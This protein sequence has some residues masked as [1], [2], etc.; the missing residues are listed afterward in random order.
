M[1][2]P[3]VLRLSSLVV[4]V[5]GLNPGAGKLSGTNTYLVGAGRRR[6]LV[7][8]GEGRAGYMPALLVAM[9]DHG[10]DDL[11]DV[12]LTHYHHDHIGGLADLRK[13]FAGL[14]AWKFMPRM[15]KGPGDAE[16]AGFLSVAADPRAALLRLLGLGAGAD[17]GE[18]HELFDG[19]TLSTDDGS[20]TLRVLATPGHTADHVCLRLVEEPSVFSGDCV[21]G[22]STAV[23]ADLST[24]LTSLHRLRAE[25][26]EGTM[27]IYPGHGPVVADAKAAVDYYIQHRQSRET[28][29]LA[30]MQQGPASIWGITRA[31]YH[32]KVHW[33]LLPAAAHNVLMH[34]V[35]LRADGAA[36]PCQRFLGRLPLVGWLFSRWRLSKAA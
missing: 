32:G 22:G 23:F 1:A 19:S 10:C 8:A 20:A 31:L 36:T 35:K 30:L 34:L 12:V 28:Q 15:L 26:A 24:Y 21:L 33:R 25:C 16:T 14:K 17:P 7:D 13:H 3:S 2:E 9:R 5:M 27:R 29:I 18:L 11:S 4:R 6:I